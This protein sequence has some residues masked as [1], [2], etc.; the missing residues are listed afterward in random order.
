MTTLEHVLDAAVL[1]EALTSTFAIV[2][3]SLDSWT[4]PMLGETVRRS[5]WGESRV[6]ARGFVLERVF[7]H[8]VY[9]TAELNE[10]LVPIGSPLIEL[11]D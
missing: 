4:L 5:D 1:A 10:M 11:W 7:A 3:R 9:H 8:D 2:E 6:N